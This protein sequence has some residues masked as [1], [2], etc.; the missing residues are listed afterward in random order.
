MRVDY[1]NHYGTDL[2]V[3]NAA[4]TFTQNRIIESVERGYFVTEDGQVFGPKGKLSVR[5]HGKQRYPTYTTN[6]G[7][8]VHGIPVHKLAAYCFYGEES[9]REG[10]IVRH[11]NS[12]VLDLSKSNIVLGS[13]SDNE[14]DKPS[15]IRKRSA[16]AARKA[17]GYAAKNRKLTEEQVHTIREFY[18]ELGGKKAPQGA[19]REL[20]ERL[21]VSRTVLCKIKNKEYYASPAY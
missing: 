17:Q 18:R 12:D 14:R 20:S 4:L 8:R 3:V 21:G 9:F 13:Y 10:V 2:T 5:Q 6:W 16:I 15:Y 11:L 1:V 7:G 19:V